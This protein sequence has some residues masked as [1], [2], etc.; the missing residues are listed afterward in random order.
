MS[1]TPNS[2]EYDRQL[3]C[4]C[5]LCQQQSIIEVREPDFEAWKAGKLIQDAFP[6][7]S[8][9]DRELM[10]SRTCVRCW[11]EMFGEPDDTTESET[12]APLSW[13]RDDVLASGNWNANWP[14]SHAD[15]FL[16]QHAKLIQDR[17]AELGNDIIEDLLSR[18]EGPDPQTK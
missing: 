10:I 5:R 6:Y 14:D 18:W 7:L 1:D 15:E 8:R 17:L 2:P 16:R 13:N 4:E 11:E 9:P 12:F 3:I